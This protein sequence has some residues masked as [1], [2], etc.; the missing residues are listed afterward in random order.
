MKKSFLTVA[1]LFFQVAC[2]NPEN[3]SVGYKITMEKPSSQLFHVEL[4][5]SGLKEDTITLSMPAWM[6]GYYQIMNYAEK[7]E[8]IDASDSKGKQLP[9]NKKDNDSWQVISYGKAFKLSY[10]VKAD[11]RFV[12]NNFLDSTRAYIVPASTFMFIEGKKDVPVSVSVIPYERWKDIATGLD[13]VAGKAHEFSAPDFDILYDCPILVGNLKELPPF[14]VQG[15]KHRFIGYNMGEFDGQAL[16]AALKKIVEASVETIGEVPYNQYTF[17]GIGPGAGGI[18]HLNNTT[19]SFNGSRLSDPRG[20]TGI[21]KFLAHEYFHNFNVKRIRPFELGP[22]DYSRENRTNLLWV[23][24]GMTVYYEY[25]IMKRAGLLTDEEFYSSL[26][27]N[28]NAYENDPGKEYQSLDQA[29]YNTWSD[30]PFGSRD[31]ANDRSISVYDKGAVA[32]FILDLAIRNE[33]ANSKSMDDVMRLLYRKYYRQLGRGF[34]DAEFQD[35]CE[36]VSGCPLARE[37]EYVQTTKAIDY[38]LYLSNAGLK[39]NTEKGKNGEKIYHI[40]KSEDNLQ[41]NR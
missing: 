7:V 6:P 23:S 20:M 26:E 41:E 36:S 10:E 2:S 28:I 30:G 11:R 31:P 39:I 19:V 12:A 27:S 21:L 17:I 22:F 15:I 9:V 8:N 3:L 18:E 35:A 24:E 14:E 4:T 33:T 34:T 13:T 40:S 38:G 25:L 29:S 32:G 1:G 5:C 37:F 16:M